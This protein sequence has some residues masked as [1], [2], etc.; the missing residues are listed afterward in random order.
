M[1]KAFKKCVNGYHLVN[2][3]FINETIWEDINATIFSSLGMEIKHQSNGGHSSG[4]DI[5][6]S[7][8]K[9]S[10][11]SSKYSKNKQSF[12]ISSYR[13]T[14][15]C[16]ERTCG[17]QEEIIQEINKRK[18]FDYYS[19]ILR[20]DSTYDWLLIPSN[21]TMMDP[22][23]YTWKPKIGKKGKNKDKQVGWETNYLNGCKMTITFSMSSQLWIHLKTSEIKDFIIASAPITKPKY[24]YIELFDTFAKT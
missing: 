14:T 13:L 23:S 19:I 16:S 2:G 10:N 20:D 7:Y 9:I 4:M 22:S 21:W 6:C 15:V 11:K 24:N 5:D 8:G 12:D 17:T 18:N 3:S 1:D